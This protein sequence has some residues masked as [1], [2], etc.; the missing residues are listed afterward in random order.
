M[1]K[2]RIASIACLLTIGKP[3]VI[4]PGS[5]KVDRG[6]I[7]QHIEVSH[8][9]Q[10]IVGLVDV[11]DSQTSLIVGL[12]GQVTNNVLV[13]VDGRLCGE[14]RVPQYWVVEVSDIPDVGR[15]SA[16]EQNHFVDLFVLD[17]VWDLV[18]F[19]ATI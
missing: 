2:G 5:S 13:V 7:W 1:D 11:Q 17:G 10:V 15:S 12:E 19:V 6:A 16:R 18:R 3:W 8:L 14:V 9:C 4:A